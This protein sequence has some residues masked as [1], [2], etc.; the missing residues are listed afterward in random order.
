MAEEKNLPDSE[1][2]EDATA[3][4]TL[5]DSV[6][7]DIFSD[8]KNLRKLYLALHPEDTDITEDDLTNVTIKNVFLNG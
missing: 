3:K 4:H 8:K 7:S 2:A 1:Q 6:F 5:K